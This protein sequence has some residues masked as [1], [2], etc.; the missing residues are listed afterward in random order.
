MVYWEFT[1]AVVVY[2][3]YKCF[4]NLYLHPLSGYP[5]PKL[6]ALG[7]RYEFYH[8][9]IR[10]GLFLWEIEKMHH[11]YGKIGFMK[12][13]WVAKAIYCAFCRL[14]SSN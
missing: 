4:Y 2:G 3:L 7:S 10:D 6:V 11:Q 12:N 9:V 13:L 14:H 8:D 5:G 1:I